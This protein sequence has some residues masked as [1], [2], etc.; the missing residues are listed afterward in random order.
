M[1]TTGKNWKLA[2][3]V[4]CLA[5]STAAFIFPVSQSDA[6]ESSQFV[7]ELAGTES[8]RPFGPVVVIV[9]RAT[10]TWAAKEIAKTVF[11]PTTAHSI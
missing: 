7:E 4:A 11:T 6:A 2:K 1:N 9:A 8:L 3:I 10:A 5:L